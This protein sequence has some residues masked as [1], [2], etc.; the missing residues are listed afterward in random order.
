MSGWEG[1]EPISPLHSHLL[2]RAA[3]LQYVLVAVLTTVFRPSSSF[4]DRTREK[5]GFLV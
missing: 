5:T 3:L 1:F 2:R 4:V